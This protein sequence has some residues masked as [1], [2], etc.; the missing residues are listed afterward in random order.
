M[1]HSDDNVKNK[2]SPETI[3]LEAAQLQGEEVSYPIQLPIKVIGLHHADLTDVV[4]GICAEHSYVLTVTE[5]TAKSS[6]E[7][8]YLAI[9]FPFIA[10]TREHLNALYRS[11][12]AH[13]L[14][15]WTL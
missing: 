2:P 14:I 3:P 15:K 5:V 12:E 1:N 6:K 9:T 11:L 13:E 4:I 8:K 10:Q 7:A